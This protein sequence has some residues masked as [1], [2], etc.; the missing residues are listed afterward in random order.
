MELSAVIKL[1][2]ESIDYVKLYL[3]ELS[4]IPNNNNGRLLKF[5]QQIIHKE[6]TPFYL[7]IFLCTFLIVM[8]IYIIENENTK[9]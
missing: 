2:T 4:S 3:T 1:V 5:T 9:K 7:L 6:R 8:S